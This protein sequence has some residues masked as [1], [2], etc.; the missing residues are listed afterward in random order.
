MGK[1]DFPPVTKRMAEGVKIEVELEHQRLNK[2]AKKE[3]PFPL[4]F[5]DHIYVIPRVNRRDA[6]WLS[7]VASKYGIREC[8]SERLKE[9]WNY[10]TNVCVCSTD[11]GLHLM[12]MI[13]HYET[14][15]LRISRTYKSSIKEIKSLVKRVEKYHYYPLLD[16][17][18]NW[19]YNIYLNLLSKEEL[20]KETALKT[21]IT[22]KKVEIY[23]ESLKRLETISS[24]IESDL[25]KK[26]I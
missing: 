14:D 9:R 25:N 17:K 10:L 24:S 15:I 19:E 3:N 8:L 7:K 13:A 5:Q 2:D 23:N 26:I 18:T 22:N 6:K 12:S 16:L 1:Y 21:A 11:I 4:V 20:E